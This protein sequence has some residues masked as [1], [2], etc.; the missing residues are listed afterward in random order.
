MRRALAAVAASA[1]ALGVSAAEDDGDF[2]AWVGLTPL[3][4]FTGGK[5]KLGTTSKWG[6]EH[7]GGS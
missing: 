2:A 3:Q 5:Q 6:S 1:L 7:C 4:H